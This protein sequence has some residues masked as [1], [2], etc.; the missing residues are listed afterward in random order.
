MIL[1]KEVES[2]SLERCSSVIYRV[3]GSEELVANLQEV[4]SSAGKTTE[5]I[6]EDVLA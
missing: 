5:T 4:Q 1:K 6:P 2:Y 3:D